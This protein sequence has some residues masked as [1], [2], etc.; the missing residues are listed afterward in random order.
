MSNKYTEGFKEQ[1][2][3]KALTRGSMSLESLAQELNVGY[4]TIQKWIRSYKIMSSHD[5]KSRRPQDWTREE[6]LQAIVDCSSLDETQ[7]SEYCRQ[8]VIKQKSKNSKRKCLYFKKRFVVKIRHWQKRRPYW[9]FKKSFKR[10][11]RTR[12]NDFS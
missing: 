8:K 5:K 9:C 12:K 7:R 11:W 2:V 6:Q 3:Q 1:A 10:C 4:S